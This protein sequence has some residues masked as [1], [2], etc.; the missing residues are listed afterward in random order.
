[1][2][3]LQEVRPSTIIHLASAN[4]SVNQG[5]RDADY[6]RT[7]ITG[8]FNLLQACLHTNLSPFFV[9]LSSYEALATHHGESPPD[10][11]KYK[12]DASTPYSAT[13]AAAS[14]L[15]SAWYRTYGLKTANVFCSNIYGPHQSNDKL[16]PQIIIC[17]LQEEPIH[18]YG[19]GHEQRMWLYVSDLCRGVASLIKNRQAGNFSLLGQE[20]LSINEI[21]TLTSE[22][23]KEKQLPLAPVIYRSSTLPGRSFSPKSLISPPSIPD[24][25]PTTSFADGIRTTIDGFCTMRQGAP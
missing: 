7:N 1:M 13:K 3:V 10:S 25:R 23:L 5:C 9:H 4:P 18:I 21:I 16:I 14:H 24:W 11:G 6:I 2:E 19:D 20:T 15:V 22:A 17:S 8:T 12:I